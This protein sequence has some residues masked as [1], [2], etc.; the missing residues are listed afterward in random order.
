MNNFTSE[1]LFRL[2]AQS[3]P[4]ELTKAYPRALMIEYTSKCNLRCKYCTKSNPGDDDIPGRNSDMTEGL[5]DTIVGHLSA[6]TWQDAL[7]AGTGESTF[8]ANWTQDFPRLIA[9]ARVRNPICHISL[10]SNFALKYENRHWDVFS[11]LDALI[12]SIDTADSSLTKAVRAKSD[13][14][15]I[16]YNIIKFKSYC[17]SHLLKMPDIFINATLYQGSTEGLPDLMSLLANLPITQVNLSDLTEVDATQVNNIQPVN[18]TD[19][20]QFISAINDINK[21]ISIAQSSKKFKLHLQPELVERLD[22]LISNFNNGISAQAEQRKNSTGIDAYLG[23]ITK[24]CLQPWTRFTIAADG[25]LYPCCVTNMVPVG[26]MG[27]TAL[28]SVGI[29][30]DDIRLFRKAL[31]CGEVPSI[32]NG[33]SNAPSA[34]VTHLRD[35]ISQLALSHRT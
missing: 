8:H 9:A 23:A 22:H 11:K 4:S 19:R 18:L 30:G 25:S 29:N 3:V 10:N 21:S 35:A 17:D 31:L 5:I 26:N 15:L 28:P 13:L 12:I 20:D 1:Q 14:S 27:K 34:T 24:L 16:I 6:H 33:C 7:L 32:C 2:K